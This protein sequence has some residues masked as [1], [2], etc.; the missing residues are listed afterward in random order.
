MTPQRISRATVSAPR[1]SRSARVSKPGV[2]SASLAAR[3]RGAQARQGEYLAAQG[4]AIRRL[5]RQHRLVIGQR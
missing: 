1:A 3:V 2:S 5:D 4:R